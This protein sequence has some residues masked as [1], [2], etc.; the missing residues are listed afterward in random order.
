MDNTEQRRESPE[1]QTP[2]KRSQLS[3][4]AER[5]YWQLRKVSPQCPSGISAEAGLSVLKT[6]KA[7]NELWLN[8]I[9]ESATNP[10][11]PSKVVDEYT[12]ESPWRV[13]YRGKKVRAQRQVKMLE[14]SDA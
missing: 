8:G 14:P 4:D 2:E 12:P 9:A 3:K 6:I 7:L 1:C 10:D 13:R 11:E 5:I